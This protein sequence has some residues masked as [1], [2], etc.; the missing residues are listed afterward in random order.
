M[1]EDEGQF[2][3]LNRQK[4]LKVGYSD[5]KKGAYPRK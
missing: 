3:Q 5:T 4:S 1:E 2:L